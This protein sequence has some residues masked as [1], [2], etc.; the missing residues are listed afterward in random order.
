MLKNI[1]MLAVAVSL[2]LKVVANDLHLHIPER[3]HAVLAPKAN[4]L[5]LNEINAK[6]MNEQLDLQISYERLIQTQKKIGEAR[7]QYFPYGLN[8]VAAMYFL[9][10]WN[11]LLLVE[12]I[13]SLPSK[14]FYVQSEKN[15]SMAQKYGHKALKENIKNQVAGLYYDILKEE[16]VLKLAKMELTLLE[17]LYKVVEEKVRLGLVS[18]QDLRSLELRILDMR[19]ICLKF[20]GYLS[21][22]KLA[23]NTM[24]SEMPEEARKI[25]LQTVGTFLEPQDYG[26]PSEIIKL[27]AIDRSPEIVSAEYMITAAS[28]AKNSTAWSILSFNGI[29]FNYWGRM[30]IAGSKIQQARVNREQTEVTLSNQAYIKNNAFHRTLDHFVSEKEVFKG[31]EAHFDGEFARFQSGDIALDRLIESEIIYLR[32]F[33]EMVVA[34]YES[35]KKLND[36]ERIALNEVKGNAAEL[37]KIDIVFDHMSDQKYSLSVKSQEKV[38]SVEYVFNR[39]GLSTLTVT[40]PRTDFGVILK[41]IDAKDFAGHVNVNYENGSTVTKQFKF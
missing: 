28:K 23:F 21:A 3:S 31:T 10:I 30:Q 27:N 26:L 25:D 5:N 6:L 33:R 35:L 17:T 14:I 18:A 34:H 19:D 32:D 24:I 4:A 20:A 13:T 16:S 29:G 22:E 39:S 38:K 15:M 12:L 7:A 40:N 8:T 2:P 41:L 1:L 36:L 37:E 11:P 9:N